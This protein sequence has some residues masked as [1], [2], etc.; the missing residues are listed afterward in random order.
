[1]ETEKTKV[2]TKPNG[3]IIVTGEFL[4]ED[5]TGT[6]K[7]MDRLVLCRCGASNIMPFCDASHNRIGFNSK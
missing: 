6:I 7:E 1:M 5:E 4:F 3:P 2:F